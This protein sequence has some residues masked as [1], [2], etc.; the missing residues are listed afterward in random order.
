[1]I[2]AKGG[3]GTNRDRHDIARLYPN[4]TSDRITRDFRMWHS[5]QKSVASCSEELTPL[6]DKIKEVSGI[7]NPMGLSMLR[8]QKHHVSCYSSY[9]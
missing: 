4:Q 8:T 7:G 9:G 1:M 6:V 3:S 5:G 2:R